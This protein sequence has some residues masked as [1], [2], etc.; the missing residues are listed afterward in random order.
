MI[1]Y[2]VFGLLFLWG[3]ALTALGAE[4]APK[5]L[6]GVVTAMA[7]VGLSVY[8]VARARRRLPALAALACSLGLLLGLA[9]ARAQAGFW[10]IGML[11]QRDAK[12]VVA[13]APAGGVQLQAAPSC[14][15]CAPQA[16][17]VTV[18]ALSTVQPL[19]FIQPQAAYYLSP[20]PAYLV[21]PPAATFTF[22]APAQAAPPPPMPPAAAPIQLQAAPA[23]PDRYWLL[24]LDGG[25]TMT[26]QPVQPRQ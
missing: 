23:A 21:A 2:L 22:T 8:E 12:P 25:G 19:T 9:P 16:A 17:S 5:L 4:G 15:M 10:H 7:L 18:P 11:W 14:V 20:Q 1:R 24:R 6:F 13:T 3:A 26:V